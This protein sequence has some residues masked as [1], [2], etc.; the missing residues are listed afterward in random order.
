MYDAPV[1]VLID[2]F[3]FDQEHHI[4]HSEGFIEHA[5]IEV[6]GFQ[7]VEH[8]QQHL[9]GRNASEHIVGKSLSVAENAFQFSGTVLTRQDLSSVEGIENDLLASAHVF[10]QEVT[11]QS[12]ACNWERKAACDFQIDGRQGDRY[13]HAA[14]E[15]VVEE[16]VS[17]IVVVFGVA[18]ESQFVEQHAIDRTDRVNRR[19]GGSFGPDA[20]CNLVQLVDIRSDFELGI[21]LASHQQSRFGER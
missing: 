17:R 8:A 5:G 3:R 11:G 13:S 12:D 1:A 18:S 15:N 6:N 20:V 21:F 9:P 2:V 7:V 19:V 16:A 14:L 4:H 10:H